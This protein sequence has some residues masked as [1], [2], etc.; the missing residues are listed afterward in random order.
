MVA[1]GKGALVQTLR[2]LGCEVE[3][4]DKQ[5]DVV[6]RLF[7]LRDAVRDGHV[8]GTTYLLGFGFHGV[9]KMQTHAEGFFESPAN[10]LQDIVRDGPAARA[11]HVRLVEPAA[12]LHRATWVR[13][14]QCGDALVPAAPAGWGARGRGSAGALGV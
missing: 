4:V 14:G 13:A 5:A 1:E 6:P 11:G 12:C 9:P 2:A 3:T 10:A 7:S 8:G